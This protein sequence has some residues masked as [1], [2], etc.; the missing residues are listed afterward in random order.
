[1]KYDSS[2]ADIRATKPIHSFIFYNYQ[3]SISGQ[4]GILTH[5]ADNTGLI[6]HDLNCHDG[7]FLHIDIFIMW[8]CNGK[9]IVNDCTIK[10]GST[11]AIISSNF[12]TTMS[13]MDTGMHGIIWYI[14]ATQLV[15]TIPISSMWLCIRFIYIYIYFIDNTITGLILG[16]RLANERR[17]Y[18]V[19]PSLIGWVQT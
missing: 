9:D 10:I 4:I 7:S 11:W 16:L 13:W 15:R 1:M 17:R 14:V 6:A 8:F 3:L 12:L 18:E 19:T 5:P 2:T